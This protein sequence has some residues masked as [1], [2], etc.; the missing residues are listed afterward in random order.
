M[1][2]GAGTCQKKGRTEITTETQRTQREDRTVLCL[3]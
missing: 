1:R 2:M 3:L